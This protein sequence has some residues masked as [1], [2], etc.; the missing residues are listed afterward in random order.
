[1]QLYHIL[2]NSYFTRNNGFGLGVYRKFEIETD[3]GAS[4]QAI[5]IIT[6]SIE[7][8]QQHIPFLEKQI[9]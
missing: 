7:S 9:E 4:M 5:G 3:R 6:S 2:K 8:L 1:M